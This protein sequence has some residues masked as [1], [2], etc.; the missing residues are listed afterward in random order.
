MTIP[1]DPQVQTDLYFILNA[2]PGNYLILLPD[3]PQYTIAAV[4]DAYM[5]ATL[6]KREDIIGR[7][8][9]E[10][11]PDNPSLPDATGVKNLSASLGEVVKT[12][13]QHRMADQRYDVFNHE[14]GL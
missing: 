2:A 14:T 12:K 4:T 11:F 9:F 6:T 7:G 5:K 8:M 10:V 3:P 1:L 13:R